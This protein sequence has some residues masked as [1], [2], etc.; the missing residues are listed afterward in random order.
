[1]F[2]CVAESNDFQQYWLGAYLP[3]GVA[4]DIDPAAALPLLEQAPFGSTA[5]TLNGED[6]AQ[7]QDNVY[8][9]L[10]TS[11][12]LKPDTY[13]QFKSDKAIGIDRPAA[14]TRRT[15]R[16]TR[17]RRRPTARTSG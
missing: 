6:S 1:M 14:S 7:N 16:T 17:S 15:G 10:T 5:F 12:I 9:F 8:S 4:D 13:P 11:S 3:I 2:N